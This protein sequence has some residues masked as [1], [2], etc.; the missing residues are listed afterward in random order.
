MAL[1]DIF[2]K[3]AKLLNVM[4]VNKVLSE[5]DAE[6]GQLYVDY[7]IS[8]RTQGFPNPRTMTTAL[9]GHYVWHFWRIVNGLKTCGGLID[10]VELCALFLPSSSPAERSFSV[11]ESRYKKNQSG[12]RAESVKV[13]LMLAVNAKSERVREA[14]ERAGVDLKRTSFFEWTRPPLPSTRSRRHADDVDDADDDDDDE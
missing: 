7:A 9:Y 3:E 10:V 13:G 4:K 5:F 12:L 1:L 8:A 2:H 6:A 14:K 11:M